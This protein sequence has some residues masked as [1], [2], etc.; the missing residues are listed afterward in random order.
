MHYPDPDCSSLVE[1]IKTHYGVEGEEVV[2]GNGSTEILHL[3][4][5]ALGASRAVIPVP[6]YIDYRRVAERAGLIV[7]ALPMKEEDGFAL[8]FD[9][10]D[11]QLRG[12]ELVFIGQPNNPTGLVADGD[13]LRSLALRRPSTIFIV[14]EAFADFVEDMDSLTLHRPFNVVVL[15]SFTKFYA[16]PGLRL[17]CAIADPHVAETVRKLLPPWSVNAL[18]QAVGTAALR[19]QGYAHR[20]RKLVEKGRGF[21]FREL[22]SLPGLIPYPSQGNF[23]LVRVDRKD[24]N[25]PIL[26]R[27]LLRDGI[28]IRVCG[29]YDGLDDRF[30]RVAVRS[31]EENSRLCRSLEAALGI[32]EKPGREP[33]HQKPIPQARVGARAKG[34]AAT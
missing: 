12:D 3:L 15:R 24:V 25:A 30:F 1:G 4:P 20:S 2:V 5:Q 6:A 23:L 11:A 17:G 28:G 29:N 31:E 16:I 34:L 27:L 26:A 32:S 8:D 21:L 7:K 19:D 14:D 13:A 9:S 10:L 22:Q 18:A 33:S